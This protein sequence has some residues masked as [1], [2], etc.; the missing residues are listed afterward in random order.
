M[1]KHLA[2]LLEWY[3]GEVGGEAFFSA[4]A[5]GASEPRLAAKWR[6]LAQLEQCVAARLR[7]E[8]EARGV[9]MPA[10]AADLHRGVNSAREYANLTWREAL[11]RLRPELVGYV[12]DFQAAESRMPEEILPL[13][14]FVT[15]HER[16]LL[17]FVTRELDQ[18][19]Q[20]SL[21]SVLSLLG[22]ATPGRAER[23]PAP[24]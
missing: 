3:C 16:A 19:G 1:H 10:A 23:Q 9:Q 17:E 22:E 11:T 4:L 18:D 15:D 14:R 21:D 24:H 6:K 12:R 5:R 7:A 2:E 13:A 8:L 20:N